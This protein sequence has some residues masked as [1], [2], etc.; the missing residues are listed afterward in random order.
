[1]NRTQ[2]VSLFFIVLLI[3]IV[4]QVVMI[5]LP[6][7]SPMFW[8]AIVA[9]AFYPLHARV[10]ARLGG[11][12]NR[13]ALATTGL[14]L[15]LIV[16]LS[17]YVILSI[18]SESFKFYSMMM[19]FVTTHKL[20]ALIDQIRSMPFVHRLDEIALRWNVTHD[21]YRV[22]I[23]NGAKSLGN[24]AVLKAS[25]ITRDILFLPLHLFLT[26]FLVFF[27]LRD[28]GKIYRFVYDATPMEEEHKRDVFR[29]ITDTFDAVIRGQLLTA[30]AQAGLA[31][32]IFIAL[33]LPL[34]F[35]LA[36]LTFLAALIPVLG[37]ALVWGPGVAYLAM[38]G[39]IMKAGILF[40]CGAF[41][42]SLID[43][44]LKPVLIGEKTK[45]PYLLLFL[46]ILGGFQVYGLMGMF[47]A[48]TVLSL[49]FVLIKIYNAK[50]L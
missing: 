28:G 40:I 10:R 29:Q 24:Y 23:V 36:V 38:N 7:A 26:V 41:G 15:L 4:A 22:W 49:F 50:F 25:L 20:E 21:D 37:G 32:V 18:A 5:L 35:L 48:P 33:G 31:G 2:L 27:F 9:F 13:S 16:P 8:A 46:G 12:E 47:L 19:D 17:V 30:F 14:I 42:I 45:L 34:P 43:N 11:H 1:M 6:F 44:F 3:F 39:H